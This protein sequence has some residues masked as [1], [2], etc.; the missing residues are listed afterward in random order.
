MF[1]LKATVLRQHVFADGI[2]QLGGFFINWEARVQRARILFIH[3]ALVEP[4]FVSHDAAA[5]KGEVP[6]EARVNKTVHHLVHI[7]RSHIRVHVLILL[8]EVVVDVQRGKTVTERNE[9]LVLMPLNVGV[10]RV[11][12]GLQERMPDPIDELCHILAVEEIVHILHI[13]LGAVFHAKRD[14]RFLH[15]RDQRLYEAAVFLEIIF[16][17]DLTSP[18]RVI[19]AIRDAEDLT[20]L[21]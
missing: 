17:F 10:A 16:L 19:D 5:L 8:A 18:A 21:Q 7:D 11:P 9:I 20:D 6:L 3:V 12:A 1:F 14:A 2:G 15:R 4:V 13:R